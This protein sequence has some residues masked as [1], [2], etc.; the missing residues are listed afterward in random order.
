MIR[1]LLADDHPILRK[2]FR[3]LLQ[4]EPDLLVVGE[5][6]DTKAG[7]ELALQLQPDV[8]L[9]DVSMPGEGGVQATRL[10]SAEAPSVTVIGLTMH[11]SAAI[12]Q[13]MLTAGAAACISKTEPAAV[14]LA[15][16]RRYGAR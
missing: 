15:A 9:M 12:R 16:I 7:A 8:V 10:I 11:H 2:A 3:A 1:V 4:N 14:V 5:A 13:A 6:A